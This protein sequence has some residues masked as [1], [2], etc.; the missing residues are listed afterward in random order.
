MAVD[1]SLPPAE[2]VNYATT[3]S[4]VDGIIDFLNGQGTFRFP[5]LPN[6]LFSASAAEGADFEL[7]GYRNIWTRDNVH[8]A[9]AH[10]VI[11]EKAK[12]SAAATSLMKFYSAFREKFRGII[13]GT[14][15]PADVMLRPHIRFDGNSLT[16]LPE[17]WSHSQ[18]DALG[19]FL[20]L[21]S[22]LTHA[23]DVKPSSTD[24]E[25]LELFVRFFA[26]VCYWEDEDSGHWEEVR[27]IAASSIGVALAGLREF[28]KLVVAGKVPLEITTRVVQTLDMLLEKGENALEV[29]LPAECVQTE[30]EKNRRHDAALVF[31][32]YPCDIF[33]GDE[34][35]EQTAITIANEVRQHLMGDYGIRRYNGD[36]Y[37]CADYK[38]LL[39][40]EVRT[41]DFSDGMS[42]RD[43]LLQPGL[44]AQ[45]CIFDPILSIF[46]ARQW[47]KHGLAEDREWQLFHLRR[48][49][50][51]LTTKDAAAGPW[52]C[53]ESYY[54]E[55]GKWVHN[56]LTPLLWTQAN[57]RLA[58]HWLRETCQ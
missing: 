27:K 42:A 31:L 32:M 15:D 19:Y 37:W 58:L 56:D 43:S 23:G 7:S 48:S 39:S 53:P 57:L 5:A 34:L 29:T 40:A 30:P 18:N 6:G 8:I 17:K 3:K 38:T 47:L 20:W 4:D 14:V 52:K 12:A 33:L 44:E 41:S 35:P 45:W 13:A 10:W 2:W 49:L 25:V 54:R 55:Q 26:T 1:L 9:H 24:W 46:H 21:Y 50:G 22:K 51:Q 36:S 16:E 11:G 28:R